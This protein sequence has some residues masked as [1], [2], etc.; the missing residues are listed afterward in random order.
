SET[1]SAEIEAK[2]QRMS[3]LAGSSRS[4]SLRQARTK[5]LADGPRQCAKALDGNRHGPPPWRKLAGEAGVVIEANPDEAIQAVP[6]DEQLLSRQRRPVANDD[7]SEDQ[8]SHGPRT[9]QHFPASEAFQLVG[10]GPIPP[11]L[12]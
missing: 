12:L 3:G 9:E 5:K 1:C 7:V 11:V 10:G 4:G 6:I 8:Q 2:R